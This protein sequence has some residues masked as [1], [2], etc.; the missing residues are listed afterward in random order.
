MAAFITS[1]YIHS[2]P[3]RGASD[4][5]IIEVFKSFA[6]LMPRKGLQ[7]CQTQQD[8]N[9]DLRGTMEDLHN[10]RWC[11]WEA[12]QRSTEEEGDG[13]I[14]NTW[15]ILPCFCFLVGSFQQKTDLSEEEKARSHPH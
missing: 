10:L 7:Y 15:Q 13:E 12:G 3:E 4:I 2:S 9:V 1:S 14:L 8:Y 11:S 5:C 6:I